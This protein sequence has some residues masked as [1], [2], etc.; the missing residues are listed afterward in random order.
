MK[1][2]FLFFEKKKIMVIDNFEE[3]IPTVW[4][5]ANKNESGLLKKVLVSKQINTK[6][7]NWKPYVMLDKDRTEIS[8]KSL[9]MKPI[10]C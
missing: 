5:I 9:G 3:G 4:I 6:E 1:N 10:L 2:D 8:V 7:K